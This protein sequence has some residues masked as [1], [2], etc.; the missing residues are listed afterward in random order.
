MS[1]ERTFAIPEPLLAAAL[2]LL[3]AAHFPTVPAGPVAKVLIDL[4]QLKPI[5]PARVLPFT[6]TTTTEKP[7]SGNV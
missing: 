2:A 1:T 3:Q 5:E 6:T 7:V 4:S